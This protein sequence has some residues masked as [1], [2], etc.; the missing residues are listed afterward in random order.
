MANIIQKINEQ[1]IS[2]HTI[3]GQ[4]INGDNIKRSN[5]ELFDKLNHWL[6]QQMAE[7]RE[8]APTRIVQN[9]GDNT[10]R[11]KTEKWL[12]QIAEQQKIK[13]NPVGIIGRIAAGVMPYFFSPASLP[14]LP[15]PS[16]PQP[17]SHDDHFEVDYWLLS[18]LAIASLTMI[19]AFLLYCIRLPGKPVE[20][21]NSI[22]RDALHK[23]PG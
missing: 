12:N 23:S 5:I 6:D 14:S 11:G 18:L 9:Y 2:H 19:A 7:Y 4:L 1:T 8:I 17:N 15:A 21:D 20:L 13:Q 10:R 3:D 16:L 22:D